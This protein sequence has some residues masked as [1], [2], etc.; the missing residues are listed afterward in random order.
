L[1][2]F[3]AP[4]V[5]LAQAP[6]QVPAREGNTWD[7]TDHQPTEAQV[8]REEKAAGVA[9]TPSQKDSSAAT[10]NQLDRQLL[11]KSHN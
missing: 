1:A 2:L 7:G 11:G 5:A 9:P 4:A 8:Q 6:G 10:V 3:A